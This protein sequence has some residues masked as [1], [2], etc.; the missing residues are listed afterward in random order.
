MINVLIIAFNR[1][2]TLSVLVDRLNEISDL[3]IL[4]SIDGPRNIHDVQKQ[5]LIDRVLALLKHP[6][7]IVKRKKNLGCKRGVETALDDF[8]M[9]YDQGIILEDDIVPEQ[10][11]FV[12]CSKLLEKYANHPALHI[13][14]NTF[15]YSADTI[16][17]IFRNDTAQVWGWATNARSWQNRI[18]DEKTAHKKLYF[19][20]LSSLCL[21][22]LNKLRHLRKVNSGKVD[23]WDYLWH[24]NI[25]LH[26]DAY[27]P[28]KN[29]IT[30]IGDGPSA[31]H[32]SSNGSLFLKSYNL[33]FDDSNYRV[34]IN[35]SFD[36]W[37]AK[38][39]GLNRLVGA[40]E[41]LRFPIF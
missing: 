11:F 37:M 26:G 18:K 7:E 14:G 35:N 23:T 34:V 22:K 19:R 24:A 30:N 36:D 33:E 27:Y 13:G 40:L 29:L 16:N 32:T 38:R 31:T 20:A 8:F 6:T 4:V 5:E 25:M 2:E 21:K 3:N 9:R 28:P 12:F 39:M 17:A 10:S 1:P 15:G 41:I